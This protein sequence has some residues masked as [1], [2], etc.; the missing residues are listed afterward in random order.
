MGMKNSNTSTILLL[1]L[2]LALEVAIAADLDVTKFGAK[3]T[4]DSDMSQVRRKLMFVFW[5]NN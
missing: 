3:S 2:L 1:L 4:G 5:Q